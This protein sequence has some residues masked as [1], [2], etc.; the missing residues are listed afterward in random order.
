M[1]KIRQFKDN[2][3]YSASLLLNDFIDE[4]NITDDEVLYCNSLLD[5]NDNI[6][7]SIVIKYKET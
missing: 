1:Y 2:F 3:P 6:V 4:N 5:S 7:V